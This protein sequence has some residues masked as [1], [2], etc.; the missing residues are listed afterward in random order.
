V[1]RWRNTP[2][3]IR[4][5][6]ALAAVLAIALGV[7][8]AVIFASVTS[9][10]REIGN[11][12]DPEVNHTTDLYLHLNDMD[13]Q[14]ANVLLVAGA[15]NFGMSRSQALALYQQDRAAVDNDLQQGAAVAGSSR[16][17]QLALVRVLDGLGKYE[18]LAGQ[19]TY[20]EQA[21][22]SKPGRPPAQALALYRQ[23]TDLLKS[24]ILPPAQ[25]LTAANAAAL[26][27]TYQAKRS[28]AQLGVIW[29]LLIGLALLAVLAGLQLLIAARHRR[30]LNP[31]LAGATL[32]V[33]V[34]ATWAAT[35][36]GG[37][38]SHL[39]VAKQDAFDSI[40]ALT[41]AR[42]ISY[43]GNADE[44]R[45]LVDPG[46]AT[47]YQEAFEAKS[48]R[49]VRLAGVT[50]VFQYDAALAK[51]I[52]AYRANHADV[53]FGGY[54]GTEFRN[55]TF[56]GE[57]AAAQ[58]TLYAYQVYQ[59]DDRRIRALAANGDLHGAIAFDT[60]LAPGNSNWAFY[61]YDT[62]LRG[63]IKINQDAFGQA[64][65]AGESSGTGWNGPFPIIGAVAIIILAL[66]GVRSRLAEYR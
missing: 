28:R 6:T 43:D 34:L 40:I 30:L 41:Q 39:F 20:I 15:S 57:R 66:A 65:T 31:G 22:T 5:L 47:A 35:V 50:S 23:A 14:L 21:A 16:A 51:A 37:Q 58:R 1:L 7:V 13:A 4:G 12:A 60:S 29:V 25:Q 24:Q 64:I 26:D 54:F 33:V 48:Q 56:T 36:L 52:D 10:V 59:R 49:L 61:R 27:S 45:F 44:S 3:R 62:A 9:G 42:A 8:T 11:Q 55:I 32:L 18:Q 46:R 38:A 53:T 2:E 17:A 19:I 63:L